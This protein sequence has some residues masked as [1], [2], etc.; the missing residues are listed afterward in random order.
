MDARVEGPIR[1]WSHS[2]L[3]EF[4]KCKRR[5]WLMHVQRIPEPQRPLPPGKTEHA[6]DRGT[7]VH[8]AC[9]A[10]V[11]GLTDSL[12][13]E[14]EKHFGPQLDLLRVLYEEGM[15]S[16]EGEWG[17]DQGW[18]PTDWKTAWHRSKLD[19]IVFVDKTHAIVIDYKTGK[20]FGNEV[21]H[22]EQMQL[23]Q[24][25]AFLRY[26]ELEEVTC[27][28]WYLDANEV[29]SRTFT[30][31]QGLRFKDNFHRR[32][33]AMTSCNDFP[34]NPNVFSCQWCMYGPWGTGHCEVGV[35]R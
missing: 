5:V 16:L 14:A 35:K 9:E 6:N 23:Y 11:K 26:P 13:V 30:R 10:Y 2:K 28:L 27:E 32:G 31:S 8:E 19:A 29:T 20:K 34:P 3:T 15:V 18:N 24:L 4:D 1:S 12:C 21:K 25:N 33:M 7:R 17:V 22:G